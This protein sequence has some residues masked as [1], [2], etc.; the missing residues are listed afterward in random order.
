[1][2]NLH[3]RRTAVA[4][5]LSL[6][7]VGAFA[8]SKLAVMNYQAVLFNSM[9]ANDATLVLRSNLEPEQKRMQDIQ[10]Q[11]ETRQSRLVTD[12]DILTDAEKLNFQREMQALVA[13]QQQLSARMQQAQQNSRD[14]F[15]RNY[16][17]VIRELV[18]A[19]VAAEGYILVIDFQAVLW[20][21]NEPDLT[22]IIL[23]QFDAQYES[24]K[25]ANQPSK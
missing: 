12:K 25:L 16:Q 5:L 23:S 1:M 8:E 9:A 19:H 4:W 15:I 21:T 13:E 22:E 6:A 14:E 24:E 11:L 7:A 20:N 10:Q 3:I 18:A 17:P 2:L